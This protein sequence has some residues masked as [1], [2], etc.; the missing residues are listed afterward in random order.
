MKSPELT[1]S[2]TAI[3]DGQRVT[4]YFK[5]DCRPDYMTLELVNAV[6]PHDLNEEFFFTEAEFLEM[7]VEVKKKID[8]ILGDPSVKSINPDI[9]RSALDRLDRYRFALAYS[10]ENMPDRIRDN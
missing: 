6:S 2:V 9:I 3:I 4:K 1:E 10:S 7:I 8:S 5:K